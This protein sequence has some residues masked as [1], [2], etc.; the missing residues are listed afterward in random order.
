VIARLTSATSFQALSNR[1]L[2]GIGTLLGAA[3]SLKYWAVIPIAAV[4]LLFA[5]AIKSRIGFFFA[6]LSGT[7][8]LLVAPFLIADA[9][10]FFSQTV[11]AQIHRNA[12]S[13]WQSPRWLRLYYILGSA[14]TPVSPNARTLIFVCFELGLVMV[15]GALLAHTRTVVWKV[16]TTFLASNFVFLMLVPEWFPYY[17]SFVIPFGIL[18]TAF[19]VHFL[20]GSTPIQK[21]V[22]R[23]G[24]DI[25]RLLSI[26][27]VLGLVAGGIA[28]LTTWTSTRAL[29]T[30]SFIGQS[31]EIAYEV[32]PNSC[33]IF[34]VSYFAIE[35][36]RVSQ[37]KN[38][39]IVVDPSGMLLVDEEQ[40]SDPQRQTKQWESIFSQ[41]DYVVL[42]QAASPF[43]PWNH[44]LT[45]YF[46][47][48][49]VLVSKESVP[50]VFKNKR[51]R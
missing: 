37:S 19:C 25:R 21:L 47:R 27:F 44:S 17:A 13:G 45:T 26:I 16:N 24:D 51:L 34:D 29:T 39:P 40:R 38:C 7:S 36:N 10:R 1:E 50:L 6:G 18:A 43:I 11:L 15:L 30:G 5:P 49:F 20:A 23:L 14:N 32:Q 12:L 33:A 28:A 8:L 2:I 22:A 4:V 9:P 41:A 35:A 46:S 42:S 3:L 48:N 31:S